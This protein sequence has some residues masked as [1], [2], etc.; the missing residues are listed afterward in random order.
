[1]ETIVATYLDA[2]QTRVIERFQIL[3]LRLFDKVTGDF[4]I[5]CFERVKVEQLCQQANH[6][7][8]YEWMDRFYV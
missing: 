2:G 1:M 6:C 5:K 3:P 7:L 8:W 4:E